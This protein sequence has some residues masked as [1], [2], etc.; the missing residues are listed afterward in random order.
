MLADSV[1]KLLG[2]DSDVEAP[3]EEQNDITVT[4]DLAPGALMLRAW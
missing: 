3:K 1:K 2:T 4:D